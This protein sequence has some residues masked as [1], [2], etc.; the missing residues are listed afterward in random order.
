VSSEI[1]R[2]DEELPL[3]D[4]TGSRPATESAR[5]PRSRELLLTK[6]GAKDST[7]EVYYPWLPILLQSPPVSPAARKFTETPFW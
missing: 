2:A 4:F 6:V 1:G 3:G 5:F 7:P